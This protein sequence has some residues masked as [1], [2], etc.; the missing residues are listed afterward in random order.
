MPF[1]LLK[2]YNEL[3]ELGSLEYGDRIKSLRKV[4]DRDIKDNSNFHFRTIPIVPPTYGEIG[5]DGLFHHLITTTV[6]YKTKHRDFCFIRSM[7][8]HWIKY[9]IEENK[10]NYLKIILETINDKKKVY[11]LDEKESYIIVLEEFEG[12][13][14]YFLLTA[15]KLNK[16]ALNRF[17]NKSL[18]NPNNTI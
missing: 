3:L 4:F 16:K 12:G 17:K 10:Q 15:F 7:R 5:F 18:R 6:N 14:F 1:N 8:L 13:K 11:I 9:H 2:K